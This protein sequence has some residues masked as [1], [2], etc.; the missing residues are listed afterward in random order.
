[1]PSL[2]QAITVAD[3]TAHEIIK[4]FENSDIAG[5]YLTPQPPQPP[6]AAD[7]EDKDFRIIIGW[8]TAQEQGTEGS[9]FRVNVE[10]PF[11]F[12]QYA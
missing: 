3:C 2:P 12:D 8:P 1:M 10:L 7:D 9:W 4:A 6:R 11:R 5:G